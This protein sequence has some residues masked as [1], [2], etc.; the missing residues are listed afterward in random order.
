MFACDAQHQSEIAFPA[1]LHARHG[2]F[3]HHG[4]VIGHAQVI[5]GSS[6]NIWFRFAFQVPDHRHLTVHT[7]V[8]QMLQAGTFKH[9]PAVF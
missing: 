7:C 9:R 6:K 8:D 3:H 2:I 4:T 5:T 1:G